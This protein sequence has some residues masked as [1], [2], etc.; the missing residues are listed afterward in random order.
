MLPSS[1]PFS[2]RVPYTLPKEPA[3]GERGGSICSPLLEQLPSAWVSWNPGLQNW[4]TESDGVCRLA[5]GLKQLQKPLHQPT[6]PVFPPHSSAA[7]TWHPV[8]AG[9]SAPPPA[10]V[11]KSLPGVLAPFLIFQVASEPPLL[12][13]LCRETPQLSGGRPPRTVMAPQGLWNPGLQSL[14]HPSL[15]SP[16]S[17]SPSRPEEILGN[18]H[19]LT[20]PIVNK[21]GGSLGHTPYSVTV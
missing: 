10:P 1:A 11:G 14:T 16:S 3:E 20:L 17:V 12:K 7:R 8:Q 4:E 21:H 13:P 5:A 6:G 15:Q 19:L 2:F 9:E 18:F